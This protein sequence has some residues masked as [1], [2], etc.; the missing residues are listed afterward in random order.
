MKA[1]RI[2]KILGLSFL[3]AVGFRFANFAVDSYRQNALTG[4][5][6]ALVSL[7]LETGLLR[8]TFEGLESALRARGEVHTCVSVTDNGR[9]YSP[10]CFK[11]GDSYRTVQCKAAGNTGV[12][13]SISYV[14]PNFFS[15][16]FIFSW[17][18]IGL[19][20]SALVAASR[21]FA[22]YLFQ[23]FSNEVSL[24]F[25][26][27]TVQPSLSQQ[28]A[29]F[30]MNR[31][32][33]SSS[34]ARRAEDFR[35]R[36]TKFESEIANEASARARSEQ[37]AESSRIYI[38]KVKKIRH[39]IRSPLSSLQAVYEKLKHDEPAAIKALSTAINR[40]QAL[41]AELSEIEH[42]R[43]KEK[44]VI[45]EVAVEEVALMLQEKFKTTK[46]ASLKV[47]YLVDSLS[48]IMVGPRE[49]QGV[50]ENLLE[51]ALEAIAVGG[52]V[53]VSLHQ[54]AGK[55][56][57]DVEDNGCGISQEN[58]AKLFT[59]GGSFG[60]INGQGLGLYHAK[61]NVEAW[62]GKIDYTPLQSGTKF[63]ISLPLLQTGVVFAGLPKDRRL[64]LIDDD[65][66][67]PKTLGLAGYEILETAETFAEGQKIL[68]GRTEDRVTILVD[69]RLDD[70]LLG[71]DLIAQQPRRSQI[72]LCTNDFDDPALVAQA[73]AI[74]VKIIPKPLCFFGQHDV[75]PPEHMV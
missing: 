74:G 38:E 27:A 1:Q 66:Q 4:D 3:L 14:V 50:I 52:A 13:A 6:C 21:S 60:K 71:T 15:W 40:I 49:F 23:V 31:L 39:D 44:L 12:R 37:E 54:T 8:D 41:S 57:I 56:L 46:S 59:P 26:D 18:G 47:S 16:A 33:I 64:K 73:R 70:G 22:G 42:Q 65:G 68:A 55:C 34:L 67:I 63:T 62:S 36:L 2:L 5:L 43:E 17:M 61:M 9:S 69:H 24:H 48:P 72:F 53:E 20:I 35:A 30:I 75:Q 29:R 7:P 25:C 32:G 11:D 19:L 28:V 51:N 10:D 45:A 58:L